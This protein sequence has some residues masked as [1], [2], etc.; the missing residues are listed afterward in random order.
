MIIWGLFLLFIISIIGFTYLDVKPYLDFVGD[1]PTKC[2]LIDKYTPLD[3][4][5]DY[6]L[7]YKCTNKSGEIV[8]DAGAEADVYY[9]LEI[10]SEYEEN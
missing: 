5:D 2:V 10:G 9:K 1:K 4:Y 6:H 3:R 7:I 8:R